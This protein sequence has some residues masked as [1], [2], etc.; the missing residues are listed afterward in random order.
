MDET[1][2]D[3]M[4]RLLADPLDQGIHLRIDTYVGES[5][6][7]YSLEWLGLGAAWQDLD[8]CR[9]YYPQ[10]FENRWYPEDVE[11]DVYNNVIIPSET[12]VA[13]VSAPDGWIERLRIGDEPLD[14][15]DRPNRTLF[16]PDD[17]IVEHEYGDSSVEYSSI[18]PSRNEG[19]ILKATV[20][21]LIVA[22]KRQPDPNR[23]NSVADEDYEVMVV[24][25]CSQDWS[26]D[27]VVSAYMDDERVKVVRNP[28]ALGL[29]ARAISACRKQVVMS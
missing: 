29:L 9:A 17:W 19:W 2:Y 1:P 28:V 20:D 5:V 21:N 24:D 11:R 23:P 25:D 22:S 4:S 13:R 26:A 3:L 14:Y 8:T 16:V 27:D 7:A 12:P 15:L 6:R 18:I 10:L